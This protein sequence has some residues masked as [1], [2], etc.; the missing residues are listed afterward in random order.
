[1]NLSTR[2][3]RRAIAATAMIAAAILIPTAALAAPGRAAL[4]AAAPP[5]KC[6][7][8][9]LTGW[10]PAGPGDGYAGGAVYELEISNTSQHPCTLY[11]FPGVS[12]LGAGGHQLGSPANWDHADPARLVTLA[13]GATA[14]VVLR[15]ADVA[16]FGNPKQPC[17]PANAVALRIYPP[18]DRTSFE[19]PFSFRACSKAGPVYLF[20]RT[21]QTGAGIPNFSF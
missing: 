7:T 9:A 21:T 13:S 18:N 11:G 3:A 5:A 12:A 15:I 20:V 4:P 19:I 17:D 2:T 8:T 16:N 6:A 1:M 10:M 14:H